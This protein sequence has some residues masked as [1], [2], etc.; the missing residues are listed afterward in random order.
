MTS[1]K[2]G[3]KQQV[4]L[5]YMSQHFGICT[6]LDQIRGITINEKVAWSG[7]ISAQTTIAI[8]KPDLFG[9]PTKQGGVKGTV[10]FLPGREDQVLPDNLA[11]KLG[12]AD[13]ADCPG[14]RGVASAFFTGPSD[15]QAGFYWTANDPYLPGVWITGTRRP[16]GLNQDYAMVPRQNSMTDYPVT[17]ATDNTVGNPTNFSQD[18]QTLYQINGPD[19]AMW[20]M[21]S[22]MLMKTATLSP[23]TTGDV[24]IGPDRIYAQTGPFFDAVFGSFDLGGQD[25]QELGPTGA[26]TDGCTWAASR[27]CFYN[28]VN[29]AGSVV[30]DPS[31]GS[32]STYS[33]TFGPTGYCTDASD[34]EAGWVVGTDAIGSTGLY[35]AEIGSSTTI[36]ITGAFNG[37]AYVMDN[38][39]G[40]L[41]VWQADHFLLIDKTTHLVTATAAVSVGVST[42]VNAFRTVTSGASTIWMGNLEYDTRTLALIRTVDTDV[43]VAGEWHLQ[44]TIYS[45]YL[46]ALVTWPAFLSPD[47]VFRLLDRDGEDANPA[48]II[49]ECLTN[50]DWGM[51]SPTTL[52]DTDAFNAAGVELFNE[53]LGL[54]M[55]WTKQATIQDFVQ[56]VLDHIQGV[57]FVDPQTG[58]LTLKLIRGDYDVATLP[59][60]S[61]STANLSNFGRKLWGDVV[62]E[63][64]VTWT[65]P[66]NEQDETVTAHD[67]ASIS[68]QGGIVSDSRNYYG[69][70]YSDLAMRLAARDLRSAGAPLATFDAEVDRSLW[71]L[72]PASVLLVDW[73]EYGLNGLVARITSI[74]YGKPGD[75]TIKLSL[76]EDVFGLDAADYVTPPSTLWVNPSADPTAMTKQAA[77]T[78]PYFLAAQGITTLTGAVYPEV[79]AGVLGASSNSDTFGYELWGEVTLTDGSTEWQQLASLNLVAYGELSANLAAEA[80]STGVAFTGFVG[81]VMPSRNALALIGSGT[82]AQNELALITG[83][84]TTF[85][86]SRGVLDTVPRAWTAGT[87]VWFVTTDDL[88]EDPNPRAAGEVVS[89]RLRTRTSKGLLSLYAAPELTTTLT[90]RPWLPLRP[91]NVKAY[92]VAFS[93]SSAPI[94]A[95][96]RPDPW[97]T[98]TW[99]NRDRLTE[100]ATILPWNGSAVTPESGQTTT[101][102]VLAADG[103]TVLATHSGLTGTSFDVPDASFGS[104]GEVIIRVSSERIDSEGT[105]E[106]LQSFDHWVKVA[107]TG[108]SDAFSGLAT[109]SFVAASIAG[110]SSLSASGAGAATLVGSTAGGGPFTTTGQFG[111]PRAWSGGDFA[112]GGNKL[113]LQQINNRMDAA[114]DFSTYTICWG[115]LGDTPAGAK[116]K[117]VLYSD[118]GSD[119]PGTLIAVGTENTLAGTEFSTDATYSFG[120]TQ[121]LAANTKYW[122]G[123]ITDTDI[124]PRSGATAASINGYAA[125]KYVANTYSS[126]APASPTGFTDSDGVICLLL[127]VTV[128]RGVAGF[129]DLYN[130]IGSD[131]ITSA[132][133]AALHTITTPASGT[134]NADKIGVRLSW[135]V[136]NGSKFKGVIY[137]DSG[138]SPGAL[139]ATG[140]EVTVT[141]ANADS[142]L[143][144]TFSAVTLSASTT[145]WIGLWSNDANRLMCGHGGNGYSQF[146][147]GG[148]YASGPF[149][150][151]SGSTEVG[152][153]IGLYLLFS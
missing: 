117:P 7:S 94:D 54:S 112:S 21:D 24:A 35:L 100:D 97:V 136:T 48:H 86:L 80:S 82:E 140:S 113:A 90:N 137:A 42:A 118:N 9:G 15:G 125:I 114:A 28:T 13:G 23:A 135:N 89:Y 96:A 26:A 88:I 116:F 123:W 92:G 43:W 32:L 142:V 44:S 85:T 30:Y 147:G 58:L 70:R 37:T 120:S 47:L 129:W 16:R 106:S 103:T 59:T 121:T 51:G 38:G 57:L 72:R 39:E 145:Y 105:F 132:G 36:T 111:M 109:A 83:A 1:G 11:Q 95:I 115:A 4:T 84:S 33:V 101:I 75:P 153:E 146:K 34:N 66:D 107:F 74:D 91:A 71:Y 60:I 69:V 141:T 3:T 56:E 134:C 151:M 8:D 29:T 14:Y 76:I 2:G 122:F 127:N 128:A 138:G 126:G 143:E 110:S 133:E 124:R 12:R 150:S 64:N 25:Y 31:A 61:P 20:N 119:A 131:F 53:P 5:Y 81:S 148:T 19:F 144:S 77:I 65:N 46:H 52:I 68:T 50:T 149:S 40:K 67:L 108:G 22:Q 99:S 18:G 78:L 102:T 93:S 104:A 87:P 73:P 130:Q 6:P 41:L 10:Y 55:I 63:I 17:I 139:V 49:Y 27:V 62:N 79:L 45:P 152:R 98:V